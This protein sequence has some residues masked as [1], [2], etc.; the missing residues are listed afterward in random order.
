MSRGIRISL[1]SSRLSS[2]DLRSVSLAFSLVTRRCLFPRPSTLITRDSIL[3]HHRAKEYLNNA[4]ILNLSGSIL[5]L[6]AAYLFPYLIGVRH[7]RMLLSG[8]QINFTNFH[9]TADE[10]I[11]ETTSE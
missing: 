10:N 11:R 3:F 1:H 6:L 9:W 8:I 4:K 7:S 5:S 2:F